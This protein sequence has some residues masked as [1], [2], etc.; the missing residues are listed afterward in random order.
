MFIGR[1][2]SGK[3]A[4]L[5]KLEDELG[6]RKHNVVCVIK[7]QRYQMLGIV[8]LL[9]QSQH[10]NFKAHAIESLWKFLLLTEIANT[11]YNNPPLERRDGVENRFF[12]FV[13]KNEELI[14][15]DFSTRLENC[16]QDLEEA[17]KNSKDEN[18]SLSISEVLHSGILKQLRIELANFL[19]QDQQVAI[20]V[21]NLDKAWKQQNDIEVLSE[22]LWG[23][24][25]VAQ[26]LPTELQRQDSRR[27]RIRLNL[28]IFLR[29]DIF[30]K[31][32]KVTPE[33]DKII[34]SPLKWDDNLLYRIIEER[35]L[36]TFET[37]LDP[38]VLWE[39]YFCPTVNGIPTKEY[40]IGAILKRPRD[41]I[42]LVN[43]A[44]TTAINNRRSLIKEED[45]FEAEKQYSL[46]AP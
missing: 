15:K 9:K 33:P 40:I 10:R 26:G 2:G 6:R 34:C 4:N 43:A 24:L 21:D 35:F 45:I 1:K 14:C 17:I 31:I 29:S 18:S 22:I 28:A 38:D 11:A 42:Y 32:R 7:P 19:L 39:R 30:H 44:V 23:L 13:E 20:L 41:I 37:V 36:S 3:T 27:Q 5:I 8:D 12:K 46:Y 25:E 16:I